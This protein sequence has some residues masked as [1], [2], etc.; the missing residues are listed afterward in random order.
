MQYRDQNRHTPVRRSTPPPTLSHITSSSY[1]APPGLPQPSPQTGQPS[2]PNRISNPNYGAPNPSVGHAPSGGHSGPGLPPYGRGGSPPPDIRPLADDPAPSPGPNYPHHH[3]HHPNPSQPGG[4]ATGAPPPAAALAA[5]EAAAARERD[6]RP[7]TGFK[8]MHEPE[9]DYKI[10]H[11]IPANGDSRSRLDNLHHRRASP[12]QKPP[13]GRPSP[14]RTRQASPP[15]RD[16]RGS[17]EARLED[18]R[19]ADEN[20]HPSDAAHHPPALPSMLQQQPPPHEHLPAMGENGRDNRRDFYEAASREIDINEDY[21]EEAE[22]EKRSRGSN[23]RNSPQRSMIN[24]QAK[25]ES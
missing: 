6:D 16:R 20:Y 18:Q 25:I 4:I 12:D 9:D 19:R 5:A 1:S 22:E 17:S 14:P 13:R 8:R 15:S 21:D 2:A 7:P 11:K 24:G 3:Y 23:G 10:S